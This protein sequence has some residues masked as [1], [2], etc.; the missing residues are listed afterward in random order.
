ML[1]AAAEG[2]G[3]RDQLCRVY[4]K[5]QNCKY[6]LHTIQ[7]QLKSLQAETPERDFVEL[8]QQVQTLQQDTENYIALVQGVRDDTQAQ[9]Q[10]DDVEINAQDTAEKI[11]ALRSDIYKSQYNALGQKAPTLP[12]PVSDASLHAPCCTV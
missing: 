8:G 12:L 5:A 1:T 4:V 9:K 2:L 10:L 3:D 11:N 7:E 6:T